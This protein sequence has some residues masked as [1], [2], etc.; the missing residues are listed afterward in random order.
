MCNTERIELARNNREQFRT[1]WSPVVLGN[2]VDCFAIGPVGMRCRSGLCQ[3]MPELPG[4]CMSLKFSG[5]FPGNTYTVIPVEILRLVHGSRLKDAEYV[6][7]ER[8]VHLD[9]ESD[10][11]CATDRYNPGGASR[12]PNAHLTNLLHHMKE[13]P[14]DKVTKIQLACGYEFPD[15]VLHSM[16]KFCAE[17][18]IQETGPWFRSETHGIPGKQSPLPKRISKPNDL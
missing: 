7:T 8:L 17:A 10:S 16:L 4:I 11:Q 5:T 18:R 14:L 2:C 13:D 9:T 15:F 1:A 3:S 12:L 6:D